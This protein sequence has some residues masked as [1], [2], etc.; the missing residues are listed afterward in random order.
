MKIVFNCSPN[1]KTKQK[2]LTFVLFS[3]YTDI[4]YYLVL[5]IYHFAFYKEFRIL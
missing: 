4:R 2:L 1:K 5:I 3:A